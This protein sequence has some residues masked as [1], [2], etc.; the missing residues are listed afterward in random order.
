M[1]DIQIPSE[2]AV[3]QNAGPA[4]K[5][6]FPLNKKEK[7]QGLLHITTHPQTCIRGRKTFYPP[8][9]INMSKLTNDAHFLREPHH[10]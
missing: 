3:S 7:Q 4:A 2:K 6:T 8:V 10:V 5:C 9:F 1:C